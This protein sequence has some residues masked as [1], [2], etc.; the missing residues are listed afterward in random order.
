MISNKE[1]SEIIKQKSIPQKR[2]LSIKSEKL[3]TL[4]PYFLKIAQK[5]RQS[6]K[7]THDCSRCLKT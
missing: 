2:E 3:T 1:F 7:C 4:K 5:I 6:I